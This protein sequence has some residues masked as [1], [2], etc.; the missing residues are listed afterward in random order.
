MCNFQRHIFQKAEAE[1]QA[2]QTTTME[3][4]E[5]RQG[6]SQL[7]L[8]MIFYYPCQM[9]LRCHQYFCL[10]VQS[11][12]ELQHFVDSNPNCHFCVMNTNMNCKY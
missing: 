5:E 4:A 1:A 6:A 2:D 8:V 9:G 3:V 7:N 10:F 11:F 12:T